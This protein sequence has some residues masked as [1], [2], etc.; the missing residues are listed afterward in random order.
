VSV[1]APQPAPAK[2]RTLA[3]LIDLAIV[4][5][6]VVV[7]GMLIA[8]VFPLLTGPTPLWAAAVMAWLFI[9]IPV[10]VWW[11]RQES[12]A[13]TTIGKR[14][15]QLR[16]VSFGSDEPASG[17]RCAVRVVVKLLPWAIGHVLVLV[18]ADPGLG[19]QWWW[20]VPALCLVVTAGL[21]SILA[22]YFRIDQRSGYDLVAGTQVVLSQS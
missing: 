21:G 17:L 19:D 6:Y 11:W 7:L 1:A 4:A 8:V 15:Y 16:V 20:A 12:T 22:G 9:E 13:G 10:A 14:F 5:G 3:G 18:A 2:A